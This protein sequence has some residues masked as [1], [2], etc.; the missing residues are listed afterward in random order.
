M[1]KWMGR[2]PFHRAEIRALNGSVRHGPLL[3]AKG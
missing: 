1:A 3:E 2:A